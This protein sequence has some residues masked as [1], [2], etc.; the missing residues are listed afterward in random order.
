MGMEGLVVISSG[1]S[2]GQDNAG[3]A[4]APTRLLSPSPAFL[5]KIKM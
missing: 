1:T 2:A 3:P 5:G 4:F